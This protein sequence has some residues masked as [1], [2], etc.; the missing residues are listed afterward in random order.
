M[1]GKNKKTSEV[2]DVLLFLPRSPTVLCRNSWYQL[3]IVI[4]LLNGWDGPWLEIDVTATMLHC[5]K[6]GITVRVGQQKQEKE[7][8]EN[9]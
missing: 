2:Q 3:F 6:G 9:I 4:F 1:P 8:G 7:R 5:F